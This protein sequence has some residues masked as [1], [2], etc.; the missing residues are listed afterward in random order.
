MKNK[1]AIV[2]AAL[3]IS[4]LSHAN[5]GVSSDFINPDFEGAS[6]NSNAAM[7]GLGEGF[8]DANC[9][10]DRLSMRAQSGPEELSNRITTSD[11]GQI[12]EALS[13]TVSLGSWIGDTGFGDCSGFGL[14]P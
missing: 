12:T 10:G 13:L 9:I 3:L 8:G 11:P 1:L 2:C 14:Q 5:D 4:T 6:G 7:D